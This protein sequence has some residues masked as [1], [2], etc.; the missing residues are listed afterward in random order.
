[1]HHR[2]LISLAISI[3]VVTVLSQQLCGQ[4]TATPTKADLIANLNQIVD[5]LES[6][7]YGVLE[8]YFYLPPK[9][10][11]EMFDM[12]LKR[13][14]ISRD[15]ILA[16]EK[17]GTFGTLVLLQGKKSA[18]RATAEFGISPSECYAMQMKQSD[19]SCKLVAHWK[20]DYF[21]IVDINRVGKMDSSKVEKKKQVVVAKWPTGKTPTKQLFLE[22]LTVFLKYLEDESYEAAASRVYVPEDFKL[23]KLKRLL[24][25]DEISKDGIKVLEKV[26]NFGLASELFEKG[27][28][29]IWTGRIK[30]ETA[31]CYG[32]TANANAEAEVVAHWIKDHFKFIRIDDVGKLRQ[33]EN[34]QKSSGDSISDK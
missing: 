24:E 5:L 22:S 34:S 6:K 13:K 19:T 11:P 26:G 31:E 33:K 4:Q 14:V 16:L 3:S 18:E 21:K 12:L 29:E 23:D 15:G 17:G 2:F 32:M 30:V 9:F 20:G 1:M 28:L 27:R 25:I 8:K 7:E 10:K